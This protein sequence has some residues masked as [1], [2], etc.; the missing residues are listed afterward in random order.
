MTDHELDILQGVHEAVVALLDLVAASSA[1]LAA[2]YRRRSLISPSVGVAGF[3][4]GTRSHERVEACAGALGW[5]GEG[6]AGLADERSSSDGRLLRAVRALRKSVARVT[7][8][9]SLLLGHAS[10]SEAYL[11]A[12]A[13]PVEAMRARQGL[14]DRIGTKWQDVWARL[15]AKG[16]AHDEGGVLFTCTVQQVIDTL[17]DH[18]TVPLHSN[19]GAAR[20]WDPRNSPGDAI[21]EQWWDGDLSSL[22]VEVLACLAA[23][24]VTAVA[25]DLQLKL[26]SVLRLGLALEETLA[27][28]R[29]ESDLG[30]LS[31]KRPVRRSVLVDHVRVLSEGLLPRDEAQRHLGF[32]LEGQLEERHG[33][34]EYLR[35]R[36]SP[37]AI[38]GSCGQEWGPADLVRARVCGWLK[39]LCRRSEKAARETAPLLQ[40]VRIDE[41]DLDAGNLSCIV[42]VSLDPLRA[43]AS[44]ASDDNY[45]QAMCDLRAVVDGIVEEFARTGAGFGGLDVERVARYEG[46][47][48]VQ[49]LSIVPGVEGGVVGIGRLPEKSSGGSGMGRGARGDGATGLARGVQG[50]EMYSIFAS[51]LRQT[52]AAEHPEWQAGLVEADIDARWRAHC[53]SIFEAEQLAL[54][55]LSFSSAVVSVAL[56]G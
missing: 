56:R 26:Q 29:L 13:T 28:R 6:L 54:T 14:N 10:S 23:I 3:D 41:D 43:V 11:V 34:R 18:C 52:I 51:H 24:P 46:S 19:A 5:G 33:W 50:A 38:P 53:Y 8:R 39:G 7:E 40:V 20:V 16:M 27:V 45:S 55:P 15:R 1:A 22:A 32:L 12:L 25:K 47:L 9:A 49:L 2:T 17:R 36:L 42:A 30:A 31:V 21:E 35:L 44:L 4:R 48:F 37:V